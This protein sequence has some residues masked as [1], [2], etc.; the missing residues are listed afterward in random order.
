M[1]YF[2]PYIY[3]MPYIHPY[4]YGM[5]HLHP[6]I[7]GIPYF[8]P[9]IY[10]MLYIHP[11]IYG[12]PYFQPYLS[13]LSLI[14]FDTCTHNEQWMWTRDMTASPSI[15]KPGLF[16]TPIVVVVRSAFIVFFHSPMDKPIYWWK[17]WA[18]SYWYQMLWTP[19]LETSHQIHTINGVCLPP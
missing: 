7:Y 2:H 14:V 9:Y 1:P 19:L 12:I 18:F 6:Y 11:H 16:T 10:G 15:N 3:E 5:L 4:I 8:H 13:R 17:S